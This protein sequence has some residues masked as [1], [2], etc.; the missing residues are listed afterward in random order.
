MASI[1]FLAT[2]N[3]VIQIVTLSIISS[4]YILKRKGQFR[5]HGALMSLAVVVHVSSFLVFMEPAFL[6]LYENGLVT[7]PTWLAL[8]TLLHVPLGSLTLAT[9]IWL[10]GSWHLQ[11]SIEKCRKRTLKS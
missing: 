5:N 6:S 8:M 2:L 7:E 4:G 9:G 1:L 3:L 10:V 11:T